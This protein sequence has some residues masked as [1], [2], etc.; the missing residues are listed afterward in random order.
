VIAEELVN[1]VREATDIVQVVSQTVA[2]K[3]AGANYKGLCPFH[4]EKTPSFTVHQGKQIFHCFGCGQGGNVFRFLMLAGKLSFPEAV[5][6]LAA[7]A[8]IVLPEEGMDP[9]EEKARVKKRESLLRLLEL[10]A[11]WFERNYLE[12]KEAEAVRAYARKRG[13]VPATA[14]AFRL[15]Y[16]PEDG[17]AL[18]R[19]AKAKG[20]GEAELEEAGL[21]IQGSGGRSYARFRGRLMFPIADSL[22]KVVGFGG[23]L[24]KD[25]EPKYLN[26]PETPVFSKGNLC[27][28]LP[29]AKEAMGRRKQALVVEG[30]MDALACH[31]A[32]LDWCV[33]T[34]G[35]ALGE[36]HARLLK[37]YVEEVLLLFDGDAA[38]QAAAR[39][40]C[41]TLVGAGLAVRVVV[42]QGAKDPDEFLQKQ[43]RQAFLDQLE[44]AREAPDF[45]LSSLLGKDEPGLKQRVGALQS[46]FP[47]LTRY[48]AEVE[49]DGRL[50]AAAKR[51]G[52]NVEAAAADFQAFRAGRQPGALQVLTVRRPEAGEAAQAGKPGAEAVVEREL[53]T[54]LL[55]HP[56][57]AVQAQALGLESGDFL[58][59]GYRELAG[60]LWGHPGIGTTDLDSLIPAGSPLAGWL[61]ELG[62]RGVRYAK[63][64]KSLE[65]LCLRLKRERLKDKKREAESRQDWAELDRIIKED[66]KLKSAGKTS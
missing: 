26:S 47:L 15:G 49:A 39:R 12:S 66:E 35:T 7:R 21:N 13:I 43:G 52:L 61:S 19:A 22:G 46:L 65:E 62:M 24:I 3:K 58:E 37:R 45:V 51:L 2:L 56:G 59:A 9:G 8:N 41:E 31:Q 10:A 60:L 27:F 63:P 44:A 32:G 30:Y 36:G 17:G 50:R 42:L 4:H 1:R 14:S 20:Y 5:R 11:A 23:R 18:A 25:G 38:G 40:A 64:E 48:P 34:L 57:L 33:A 28:A 6:E 29:Q 16:S 54:L 55:Q 53:L